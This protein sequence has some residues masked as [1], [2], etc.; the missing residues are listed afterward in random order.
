MAG[1]TRKDQTV[2]WR[3]CVRLLLVSL[4][5]LLLAGHLPGLAA[6]AT[7]ST[8]D[9]STE[10]YD[11]I[12]HGAAASSA[13]AAGRYFYL[14]PRVVGGTAVLES[15]MP[16]GDA[17]NTVAKMPRVL[18]VGDVKLPAVPKGA[19]GTPVDTGKGLEYV[20]PRGTPEIDPRVTSVRIMDPVTSGKYQYPN[21]YAVYMNEAGQ[22]V[23]PLSGQTIAP[24]HPF[25][26]IE[27]P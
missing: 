25:S 20:I 1:H 22:T 4:A 3:G 18:R 14:D 27:L 16:V 12:L 24:S 10:V 23:N 2:S 15:A 17:A 21:G 26:H 7:S 13:Y 6:A 9:T 19:V 5:A 11:G 8:Y